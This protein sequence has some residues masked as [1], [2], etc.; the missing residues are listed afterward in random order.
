MKAH[1]ESIYISSTTGGD[2]SML[3]AFERRSILEAV[4]TVGPK[5]E[6]ESDD[7]NFTSLQFVCVSDECDTD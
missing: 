5:V 6:F 1:M 2:A 7:R 3:H 4:T